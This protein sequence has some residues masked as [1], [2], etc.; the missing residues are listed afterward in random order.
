MK[1]KILQKNN[2]FSFEGTNLNFEV[3]GKGRKIIL[4]HGSFTHYPWAGFEE[5]L[6][7]YFQV[8]LLHLPGFGASDVVKG[9]AHNTRLHSRVLNEFIKSEKLQEAP[10]IAFSYGCVV[11]LQTAKLGDF[12]GKLNLI[13]LPGNIKGLLIRL[14]SFAPLWLKRFIGNTTV[15]RKKVILPMLQSAIGEDTKR[16]LEIIKTTDT[17]SLVDFDTYKEVTKSVPNLLQEVKNEIA[18]IYGDNDALR[19]TTSEF[20]K[21]PIIIIKNAGHTIFATNS[22]DLLEV[23]LKEIP[24]K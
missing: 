20:V 17:K 16:L 14:S 6:A 5:E 3:K 8:Y 18:V 21:D 13:G 19:E 2:I 4:L 1:R 15:G 23:I 22:K 11:A 24:N 10:L 9:K 12:K 7:N